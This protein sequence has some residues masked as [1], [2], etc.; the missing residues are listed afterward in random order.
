MAPVD[1]LQTYEAL[2]HISQ[3]MLCA[4]RNAEW[5]LLIRLE[6]DCRSLVADLSNQTMQEATHVR[7]QE[8][9]RQI[10]ADDAEIRDLTEPW[11]AQSKQFLTSLKLEHKLMQAYTPEA[12]P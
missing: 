9:I 12:K 1:A 10:L 5:D 6:L 3:Q 7:R 4:A 11:M 8:I 2:A